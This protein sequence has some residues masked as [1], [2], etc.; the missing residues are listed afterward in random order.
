MIIILFL[1][2]ACFGSFYLVIGTRLPHGKNV[3]NDRSK[4]DHCN[5]VLEWYELVPILSYLCLLGK[6]HHCG[7]RISALNPLV[8]VV[9][10][11]FFVFA[12][13]YYGF[14]YEMFMFLIISSLL[15]LIFITDFLYYI[16]LDSPLV[17]ASILVIILKFIY[18]TPM[19]VG[20]SILSGLGLFLTMFGIKLIG[21]FMFQRESL[22]GG[23]IKF[24]FVIGLCVGF[25]LGIV[26]LVLSTFL[27]LPY[28]FASI[29]LQKNNEVAYGPFL[30]AS[31]FIVFLFIDKFL[32]LLNA[33]SISL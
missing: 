5:H 15:V 17:V 28:S 13:L 6:C 4:C 30:V 21:D 27:A 22:G 1:L 3:I 29:F 23:D 8:E 16:I 31:L 11:L 18:F 33:I 20:L 2:G 32:N 9:M 10:G 26:V 25:R 24:A 14:S 12:Y 7:K 19:D